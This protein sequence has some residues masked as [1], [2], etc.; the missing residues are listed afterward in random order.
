MQPRNIAGK[1]KFV[2]GQKPSGF[3]NSTLIGLRFSFSPQKV[4]SNGL[5]T[6]ITDEAP[7][8]W[9]MVLET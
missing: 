3:H 2:L 8:M 6:I 9:P 4:F 1:P 5:S 7:E